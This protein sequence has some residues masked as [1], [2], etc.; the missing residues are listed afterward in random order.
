MTCGILTQSFTNPGDCTINNVGGIYAVYF[1]PWV[2]DAVTTYGIT[3]TSGQ[4][5]A[6]ASL[7]VGAS[8]TRKYVTKHET[9]GYVENMAKAGQTEGAGVTY[10][11]EIT[12]A[13]DTISVDRINELKLMQQGSYIV[14]VEGNNGQVFMVGVK[15]GC[16]FIDGSWT[17]TGLMTEK[18]TLQFKLGSLERAEDAMIPLDATSITALKAN[19]DALV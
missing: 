19:V 10:S 9:S 8:A 7:P 2:D 13:F 6:L 17:M 18:S 11:G 4:V 5:T 15:T 16:H 12:L 1:T 3:I 14:F